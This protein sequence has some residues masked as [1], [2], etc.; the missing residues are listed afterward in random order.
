MPFHCKDFREFFSTKT[1]SVTVG[2]TAEIGVRDRATNKV[3]AGV[4][5]SF[6]GPDLKGFVAHQAENDATVYTDDASA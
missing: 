3:H 1:G 5:Q 2:K 4:S 6:D